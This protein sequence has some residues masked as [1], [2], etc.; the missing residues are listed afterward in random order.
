[1]WDKDQK[2]GFRDDR[3]GIRKMGSWITSHG[4]EIS[5]FLRDQGSKCVM[6]LGSGMRFLVRK[7]DH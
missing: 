7:W 6:L 1:M 4:D 2:G 5:S 3:G